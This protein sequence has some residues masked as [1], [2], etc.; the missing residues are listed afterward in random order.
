M[1]SEAES[2]PL[3][4]CSAWEWAVVSTSPPPHSLCLTPTLSSDTL[5]SLRPPGQVLSSSVP[6]CASFFHRHPP[7]PASSGLRAGPCSAQLRLYSSPPWWL[8]AL[9]SQ[10]PVR[11][12]RLP[13]EMWLAPGHNTRQAAQQDSNR[14]AGCCIMHFIIALTLCRKAQLRFVGKTCGLQR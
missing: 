7:H 14:P 3:S 8:V 11:T 1:Q 12:L 9:V 4:C 13:L 2:R 6:S 5:I 10:F